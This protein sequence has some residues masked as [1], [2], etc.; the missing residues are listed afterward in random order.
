V[1]I[2]PAGT[3]QEVTLNKKAKAI[4]PDRHQYEQN[5]SIAGFLPLYLKQVIEAGYHN[6]PFEADARAHELPDA[7]V[8]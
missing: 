7:A 2:L 3:Q 5:G 8:A 6:A 4:V 1:D